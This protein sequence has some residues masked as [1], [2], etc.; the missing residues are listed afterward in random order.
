MPKCNGVTT[1]GNR[2]KKNTYRQYC[3]IHKGGNRIEIGGRCQYIKGNDQQCLR[4][5]NSKYCWQHQTDQ[6]QYG[7]ARTGQQQY[8]KGIK[9]KVSKESVSYWLNKIKMGNTD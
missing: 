3:A 7:R 6:E 8:G 2:C 5:S 1:K 9:I 4:K